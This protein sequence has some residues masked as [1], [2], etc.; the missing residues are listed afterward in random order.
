MSQARSLIGPGFATF[1]ERR[2]AV[3]AAPGYSG[4]QE[5]GSRLDISHALATQLTLSEWPARLIEDGHSRRWCFRVG[6]RLI[7]PT[8]G[9]DA[10]ASVGQVVPSGIDFINVRVGP[11]TISEPPHDV[12]ERGRSYLG[13]HASFTDEELESAVTRWWQVTRPEEWVGRAFVA[14]LAGFVVYSGRITGVDSI[15]VN[16]E[17]GYRRHL[18][19]FE[20]DTTDAVCQELFTGK[21][22][23]VYRGGA[24][25]MK[26]A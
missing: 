21:R 10:L 6:E 17:D 26:R 12:D 3:P 16:R 23:P 24:V 1:A 8:E 7:M 2:I 9:L 15:V 14:S 22:I 19:R 25:L 5:I 11:G 4:I 20:V 13:V 18:C